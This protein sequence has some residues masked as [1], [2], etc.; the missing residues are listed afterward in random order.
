[1]TRTSPSL[2]QPRIGV[3]AN[4]YAWEANSSRLKLT[5]E[6]LNVTPSLL[7]HSRTTHMC[8]TASICV[9]GKLN[10]QVLQDPC[11]CVEASICV[12]DV[13]AQLMRIFC[14]PTISASIPNRI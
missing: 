7:A 13:Q 6:E 11:I 1:M 9:E 3:E 8:R 10:V 2:S 4:A 5:L 12:E 14:N